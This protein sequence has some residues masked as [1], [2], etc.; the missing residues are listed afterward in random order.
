MTMGEFDFKE[1]FLDQTSQEYDTFLWLRLALLVAFVF[2][3][4][5]I[6]MNFLLALAIGD[7]NSIM[8][9]AELRTLFQTAKLVINL[10][11][12]RSTFPWCTTPRPL[13]VLEERPNE[14]V[15]ILRTIWENLFYGPDQ[16]SS[17]EDT[18]VPRDNR[19]AN[20]NVEDKLVMIVDMMKEMQ[21]QISVIQEKILVD[22]ENRASSHENRDTREP[23]GIAKERRNAWTQFRGQSVSF[24]DKLSD[25]KSLER[26]DVS[27]QFCGRN[28]GYVEMPFFPKNS[29]GYSKR[30]S[31]PQ[32]RRKSGSFHQNVLENDVYGGNAIDDTFTAGRD[33]K[34]EKDHEEEENDPEL[35]ELKELHKKTPMEEYANVFVDDD[36]GD[37]RYD[38]DKDG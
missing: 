23:F 1:T 6:L 36:D 7:T 11:R 26:R 28:G 13:S 37:P 27:T 31:W 22:E 4:P 2:L 34:D 33:L 8:R 5:V 30:N 14:R 32:F 20:D 38:L 35:V 25:A 18:A 17:D 3:M 9:Q 29:G 10:E 16:V 24:K 19:R 12:K 21:Q 15:H